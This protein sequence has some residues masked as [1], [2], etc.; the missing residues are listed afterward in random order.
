MK[1]EE[2]EVIN[3]LGGKQVNIYLNDETLILEKLFEQKY[4]Q[5]PNRSKIYKDFLKKQLGEDL[6][7]EINDFDKNICSCCEGDFS[8]TKKQMYLCNNKENKTACIICDDC[9]IKK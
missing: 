2:F 3:K 8:F 1:N 6:L 7:S 9:I 5:K 4:N